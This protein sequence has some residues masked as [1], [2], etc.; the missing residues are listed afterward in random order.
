MTKAERERRRREKTKRQK[1]NHR[2]NVI[3]DAEARLGGTRTV[4]ADI[5]RGGVEWYRGYTDVP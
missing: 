5:E 1:A 4:A 2:K 3:A